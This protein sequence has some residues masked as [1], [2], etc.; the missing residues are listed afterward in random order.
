MTTVDSMFEPRE[1]AR[2]TSRLWWLF[3]LT[4]IAWL[5]FSLIIF[6]FDITSVTTIGILFGVVA[7]VA[8]VD[9]FMA[10]GVSTTGWTIVHGILGVILVLVGIFAFIEPGSAF[11]VA[12]SFRD[13]AILLIVYVG[14]VALSKGIT[15]IFLAFKLRGVH[16]ELSAG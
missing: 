15:D 9:E 6:R 7:V 16:R 1:I 8:G 14:V 11:W 10:I 13:K 2:E 12:G 3:L 4:G 5:V